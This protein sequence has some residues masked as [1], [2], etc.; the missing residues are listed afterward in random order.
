MS[1]GR[2]IRMSSQSFRPRSSAEPHVPSARRRRRWMASSKPTDVP[3]EGTS[4]RYSTRRNASLEAFPRARPVVQPRGLDHRVEVLTPLAIVLA[5]LRLLG[6]PSA[7]A[8]LTR[9]HDQ[10]RPHVPAPAL[11]AELLAGALGV[12]EPSASDP[13]RLLDVTVGDL[14]GEASRLQCDLPDEGRGARV[15]H[16]ARV[17]CPSGNAASLA[18]PARSSTAPPYRPAKPPG[19]QGCRDLPALRRAQR[20]RTGWSCP[21][22]RRCSR[23]ARFEQCGRE[24][25]GAVSA[26]WTP[27]TPARAG[28]RFSLC[29]VEESRA[30]RPLI[31]GH[32]RRHV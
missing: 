19:H 31:G 2:A 8:E 29:S 15:L 10:R 16:P 7:Q 14:H 22:R 5:D 9:G 6:A 28:W 11:D 13:H 12:H 26:R 18:C 30:W 4:T 25:G 24:R 21:E 3:G 1:S 27:P 23:S 32:Y 20:R 17:R